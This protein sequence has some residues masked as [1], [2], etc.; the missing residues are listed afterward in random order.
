MGIPS[1]Y[2]HL[3]KTNPT[4]IKE[5]VERPTSV[6][7]LD[8][9]CAIYHCLAKLQK[10][11]PYVA[12]RRRE[13]EDEL[14]RLVVVYIIKLRDHVQPTDLLYVAV[15]GVVPMAK[16]RQQ[17]M[18]RFKSV[19]VAAEE[20][21]IKGLVGVDAMGWDRNAITPGTEFMDRLTARLEAWAMG[22]GTVGVRTVV[23]G[24]DKCGEGEQKIMS[25]L[26]LMD[27]GVKGD[28]VVYGLDADLIVLCLWHH[29]VYGWTFRLLREDVELKG[30]VK[31]NS[32]G[33]ETLLYFDINQ[34]ATIIKSK[35]AVS[36]ED[37]V[38]VMSFLGNDFVPHGLT[39]CIREEGIDRLLQILVGIGRPLV[40]RC[41]GSDAGGWTYDVAVLKEIVRQVAAMEERWIGETLFKKLKMSTGGQG[42]GYGGG[43]RDAPVQSETEKALA[44]M[45]ALPLEWKVERS[46]AKR[47]EGGWVL[48]ENWAEQYYSEFMWG[49]APTDAVAQWLKAVQWILNYYTGVGPVDMLWYYPWY[50]PPLFADVVK[51]EFSEL[52]SCSDAPNPISPVAQ[53][54]MVLPIESYGLLAP[55][56]RVMPVRRPEFYPRTWGFFSCGR[57]QLWECEP[58]IPMLPYKIVA[59]VL[60]IAKK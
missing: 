48:K 10:K 26:R 52:P 47:T 5:R 46:M 34:L 41:S 57:R 45:N 58:M 2:R 33:E 16:I 7:A 6:L 23:S 18:R 49:A 42:R 8:L 37:Y 40:V 21:Q 12:S 15:D 32:F 30:G 22:L 17:R 3:V 51:H 28:I 44:I 59:Q 56:N 35:W 50:L 53:L 19:W 9:N 55:A 38:G 1:F 29:Q 20:A 25:Y 14:I 43:S 31:L 13:F 36:M 54:V 27:G 11:T 4:L 60:K 39:L 24:V